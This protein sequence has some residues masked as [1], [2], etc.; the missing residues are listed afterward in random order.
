M[1]VLVAEPRR[2]SVVLSSSVGEDKFPIPLWIATGSA[3]HTPIR[4]PASIARPLL[5]AI[6]RSVRPGSTTILLPPGSMVTSAL[7]KV[8]T[9]AGA[10]DLVEPTFT[11]RGESTWATKRDSLAYVLANHRTLKWRTTSQATTST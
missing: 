7:A 1:R 10:N 4:H 6:S 9:G 3:P 5:S 11:G 2:S 8:T